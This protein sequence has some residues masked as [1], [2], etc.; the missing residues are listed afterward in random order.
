MATDESDWEPGWDHK[1]TIVIGCEDADGMRAWD[2]T[3]EDVR[4]SEA[5]A[6][7]R[8]LLAQLPKPEPRRRRKAPP[9][10]GV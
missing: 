3:L 5:G 10:D 4:A 9:T 8:Y 1:V 2:V 7:V 6:A